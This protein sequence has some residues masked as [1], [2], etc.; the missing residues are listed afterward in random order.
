[1]K[2]EFN[3]NTGD[4]IREKRKLLQLSREKFSE[5]ID[6]SPQFLAEIETG[7]KGMSSATLLKIC[8]GLGVSTDYIL[9]G[10]LDNKMNGILNILLELNDAQLLKAEELL[11]LF[12]SAMKITK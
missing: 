9:T 1:M 6:I 5:M 3:L 12:V 10:N 8:S 2:S 11:R 4:R 7:K